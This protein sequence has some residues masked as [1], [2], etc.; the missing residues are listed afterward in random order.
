MFIYSLLSATLLP[1]GS[2]AVLFGVLKA[3]PETLWTALSVAT[4]GNTIGGMIS[5]GMSWLLPM[6][7]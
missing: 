3:H 1:G 6:T 7:Q 4:F 2:E 5:F